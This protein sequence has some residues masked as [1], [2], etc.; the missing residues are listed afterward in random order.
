MPS[1]SIPLTSSNDIG[2]QIRY[3]LTSREFTA[4]NVLPCS[5]LHS[6]RKESSF[7]SLNNSVTTMDQSFQYVN[8]VLHNV[9]DNSRSQSLPDCLDT[10]K[11]TS[12]LTQDHNHLSSEVLSSENANVVVSTLK[13]DILK[14]N[15][16]W[17]RTW[18]ER[19]AEKIGVDTTDSH[20]QA[21]KQNEIP[22]SDLSCCN[23]AVSE[24]SLAT[25]KD[26]IC[27]CNAMSTSNALC[28]VPN[29]CVNSVHGMDESV[30]IRT[31][32][33]ANTSST[34]CDSPK[35]SANSCENSDANAS[36][37]S[38]PLTQMLQ[39]I[40]LAYSPV[41]RQ[42]HIIRTEENQKKENYV[43][44]PPLKQCFPPDYETNICHSKTVAGRCNCETKIRNELNVD[45]E[46]TVS[47]E[48][49]CSTL[50]RLGAY[51]NCQSHTDASSFSSIVSSLSDASPSM[52][53]DN[54]AVDEESKIHSGVDHESFSS[55]DLSAGEES[56]PAK[57]KRKGISS[58]FS[59]GVFSWRRDSGGQGCSHPAWRLWG[60]RTCT[61]AS[62]P[63]SAVAA[64]ADES[65]G[66]TKQFTDVIASSS[67]L[68]L[69]RRP[70]NLP[71]KCPDEEEK[72]KHE[73]QRMVEAARKKELKEAK[74]RKKQ[75]AQQL[76]QEEQLAHAARTWSSEILPKWDH[77][78]NSRK[79]KDLWWQGLPPSVRGRVWQLAI[80]N[81]LN[82]TPE[83]YDICVSRA[84][85][86]L[87]VASE[88]LQQE[89][90]QQDVTDGTD[91]PDKESSVELIQLDISRTFPNLCIFQKGGPYYDIL[92]SLLGAY[93]CY[94]PDVGYV[95]GMSF[96]AAVLILNMEPAEAFICFAN[97]LNQPC[98]M[99]FF[100]LNETVMNAYYAAYDCVFHENL[101][102]LHAHFSSANLTADLYLL[103][104]LY[105]VF[106]KA[107]PLD[108]ACRVWDVFLRDGEEFL[109]KT[110]LGVLHLHQETLL[111]LDFLHGAQFLTRLP[112]D[113]SADRLF[114]SIESIRMSVG[115]LRFSEVLASHI[116][117]T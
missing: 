87:R 36:T 30:S 25:H 97:L 61:S 28:L 37:A 95:Q 26:R 79:A 33:D 31:V 8:K 47:F 80:G 77:M 76:R 18:P 84:Q 52:N 59:R 34:F 66:D 42:L 44:T 78:K 20:S 14:S 89:N 11:K 19:G 88:E 81:D 67:A 106:A 7:E 4:C 1:K 15:E 65:Q 82:I 46:D 2:S 16:A 48:S 96:I 50:Q 75:L 93:V 70:S 13:P 108:V 103:D 22:H 99:A 45:R 111:Q 49:P 39:S 64:S 104:W 10:V 55:S 54:S 83:L 105:T 100:R 114:R 110:A 112:E 116:E 40:P 41:T 3:S 63:A 109:F 60:S 51:E 38:V 72:H 74:L 21:E 85:E 58:F 6:S 102:R 68:I 69:H 113:M 32:S 57:F 115:K 24:D 43:H 91:S 9:N 56:G 86:R 29:G 35:F 101:P 90:Q 98:H 73:Y 5:P 117:P 17:F 92:H 53:E 27:Q 23:I 62:V 12:F 71:A 94:R 107:M